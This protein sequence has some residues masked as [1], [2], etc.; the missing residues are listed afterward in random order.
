M[1]KTY[2]REITDQEKL[3]NQ[4]D[5]KSAARALEI[6]EL[7]SEFPD[8]LSLTVIGKRLE[9]P[10]SSLHGLINT[11]I[12]K[13]FLVCYEGLHVYKLGPKLLQ[14]STAY[15]SHIDLISLADP[16]MDRIRRVTSETTSLTV[17]QGNT[18]YFIHKRVTEALVQVVNPV[19]TR[20]LA[21]ATGSGKIMLAYLTAEEIDE[22]YPFDSLPTLTPFT[23]STKFGL[24]AALAEIRQLGYA[25]DNQESE[26]GLW[27]VAGCIRNSNGKPI[28]AVSVVAPLFRIQGK[29]Y[30]NWY[31]LVRDGAAEISTMLG[32][33]S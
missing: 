22:T 17:L 12:N 27:A 24:N 8:G 10:L 28:A 30:S 32:F 21:H 29:D 18:I 33:H 14:L 4:G 16:V 26:I 1:I 11:L 7:L 31:K 13:D 6:L 5:V 23:I 19:G 25:Y 9:I 2:P 15:Q 20:I 3:L